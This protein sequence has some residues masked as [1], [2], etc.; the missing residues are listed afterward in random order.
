MMSN[1][2]ILSIFFASEPQH[3]YQKCHQ[4]G[5]TPKKNLPKFFC[6]RG[7][8]DRRIFWKNLLLHKNNFCTNSNSFAPNKYFRSGKNIYASR[9]ISSSVEDICSACEDFMKISKFYRR[10]IFWVRRNIFCARRKSHPKEDFHLLQKINHLHQKNKFICNRRYSSVTTSSAAEDSF[11]GCRV[12]FAQQNSNF[13]P[14]LSKFVWGVPLGCKISKFWVRG[15]SSWPKRLQELQLS[16][17]LRGGCR[18][19]TNICER[20]RR[21]TDGFFLSLKSCFLP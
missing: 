10:Y 16:S 19:G 4:M 7:C 13:N 17:W 8:S 1:F 11:F 18:C 20:Q 21:V 14:I 12:K 2:K 5:S 9:R 3:S 15:T 6:S